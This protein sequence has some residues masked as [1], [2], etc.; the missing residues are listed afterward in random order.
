MN[1]T[2]ESATRL[3]C[4]EEVAAAIPGLAHLYEKCA[5]TKRNS[6]RT[7][8]SSGGRCRVGCT[9]GFSDLAA[10]GDGV[11]SYLS[12]APD[13]IVLAVKSRLGAT[14]LRFRVNGVLMER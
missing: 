12:T 8:L 2:R 3:A 5:E 6:R 14:T 1:L 11:L 7:A 4:S 9:D 10:V 13:P